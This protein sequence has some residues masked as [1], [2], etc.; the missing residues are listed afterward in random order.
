[1]VERG[2]ARPDL[3]GEGLALVGDRLVQLTWQEETAL[4]WDPADLSSRRASSR[5][6]GEGWGLCAHDGS[7]LVMS[8]GSDRLT[9]PRPGRPSSRWTRST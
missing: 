8:D 5:Y 1:M 3:F 2:A 6:E 4:V 7:R 9:V